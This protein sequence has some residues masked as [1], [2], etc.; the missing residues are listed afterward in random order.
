MAWF[1]ILHRPSDGVGA[2]V[3]ADPRFAE[4]V[5][6]LRRLAE[7]GLLVAAGPLPDEPGAGMAVVRDDSDSVD[8]SALAATDDLSVVRGLFTAEVRPW[9][10]RFGGSK[11]AP[12]P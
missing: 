11:D 10:V 9:D 1:V 12:A 4:H 2:G 3:F 5:A 7:R 6:F 8:V